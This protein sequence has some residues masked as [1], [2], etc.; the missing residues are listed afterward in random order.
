MRLLLILISLV[1]IGCSR[2]T[3]ELERHT[4]DQRLKTS[5][6]SSAS[7]KLKIK[8]TS[9]RVRF[10]DHRYG[11]RVTIEPDGEFIL[12]KNGFHGKAKNIIAEGTGTL[13]QNITEN[14]TKEADS[15][16]RVDLKKK[17]DDKKSEATKSKNTKSEGTNPWLVALAILLAA[18]I[19]YLEVNRVWAK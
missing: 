4:S 18:I 14:A 15:S 2:R 16:G 3:V 6:D 12:D 13:L 10:T 7:S 11:Y 5:S 19:L 8:S 17:T 9:N 1:F